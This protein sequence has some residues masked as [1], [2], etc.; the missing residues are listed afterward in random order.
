MLREELLSKKEPGHDNLRNS[1]A[2]KIIKHIKI[3]LLPYRMLWRE[4]KG[5]G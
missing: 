5:C 4:S 2:I 3:N 1:Q